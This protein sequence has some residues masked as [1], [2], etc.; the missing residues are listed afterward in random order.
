MYGRLRV[1]GH[2]A[3]AFGSLQK[4]QKFINSEAGLVDDGVEG[5]A[6]NVFAFVQGNGGLAGRVK[7]VHQAV[8]TTTAANDG[9]PSPFK[10]T[11]D[12]TGLKCGRAAGIHALAGTATS[13]RWV[14][15]ASLSGMSSPRS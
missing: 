10:R 5:S 1:V 6:R 9:K 14:T 13:T 2:D 3:V 4:R 15:I 7:A 8:M 12:I 11:N